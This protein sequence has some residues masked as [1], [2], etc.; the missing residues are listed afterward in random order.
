MKKK[1]FLLMALLCC[2]VLA[3]GIL[4]ACNGDDPDDLGEPGDEDVITYGRYYAVM[5]AASSPVWLQLNPDLTWEMSLG[6]SGTY[7]ITSPYEMIF[8]SGDT[9]TCIARYDA[10]AGAV[11]LEIE[12]NTLTFYM[13]QF[14]G[15]DGEPKFT[16]TFRVDGNI[17]DSQTQLDAGDLVVPPEVEPQSGKYLDGWYT[18]PNFTEKWDFDNNMVASSLDLY[19]RWLTGEIEAV[20]SPGWMRESAELDVEKLTLQL[21]VEFDHPDLPSVID[22]GS[23]CQIEEG[24]EM[25]LFKDAACSEEISLELPLS[26]AA[27]ADGD[28]L[29]YLQTY[30]PDGTAARV[31]TVNLFKQYPVIVYAHD[32][33]G[34]VF[35]SIQ[36]DAPY[37]GPLYSDGQKLETIEQWAEFYRQQGYAHGAFDGYTLTGWYVDDEEY[38]STGMV[39]QDAHV[40]PICTPNEYTVT[41]DAEE[42]SVSTNTVAVTYD[43]DFTF[44]VA[45]R[46]YY[47]FDG[48]FLADGTRIT[49]AN[50]QSTSGW[51]LL[52]DT[53]VYAKYTIDRYNVLLTADTEGAKVIGTGEYDVLSEVTVQAVSPLG[54]DFVG[55][56]EGDTLC[57]TDLEYTFT[58]PVDGVELTAKWTVKD[59]MAGYIFTATDSVCHITGVTDT[60]V[61]EL[62]IP[63]YVTDIADTAFSDCEMLERITVSEDNPGYYSQSGV[64][65]SNNQIEY[66]PL[67]VSGHVVIPEGV[68]RI[69]TYEFE[70]RSELAAITIPNDVTFIGWY[71][72]NG[73]SGLTS[74][75]IPDSVTIIEEYV[76]KDCIGLSSVTIGNGVTI[77]ARGAFSGCTGM[78]SVT[79]PDSVTSIGQYAFQ[80]CSSLESITLPFV[81]L[82]K[83]GTSYT[84]FGYIFGASSSSYNDDYVPDSLKEVTI[85]GGTIGD[86]AFRDCSG[87]TSV[88]IGDGVTNIESDAFS[89]CTG[90]TSIKVD[91][92]N[93]AYASVDGVLYNKAKTELIFI[94]AAVAGDITI[95]HGVT[96]IGYSAFDGRSALTSISIPDSVTDIEDYAFRDC[97]GLTSITIP[98]SVTRIRSSAFEGCINITSATMPTIA[99]DAIPQDSLQTVVLTS[100]E[101]IGNRAFY[102]CSSLTSVT[103]P[104][105]VT[106][107]GDVAFCNCS[108]LTS[109]TIPDSVTNIGSSA[110]SGCSSLTSITIPDGVTNIGGSAFYGCSGLTSITIPDSVTS[111]GQYAVQ[112]CSSL[113]SITLPF[114]GATND[115]T[116]DT[117]FGHIFGASS[118]SS[119][120]DYVPA[121]LKEVVITGGASIDDY[122]FSGCSSLTSVTIPDSVTSIGGNAFSECSS[123]TAVY[124][125]DIA[126]WCGIGFGGSASNPL[127][128]AHNLYLNGELVTDL[129]IPNGV[130]SIGGYAFSGCSSLTSVTIPDGV[131]SIGDRAFWYCSSLTFVNIGDGV[132]SIGYSAFDGCDDLASVTIPNSVTSID[133][134]AFSDCSGLTAVYITD[135]AAWCGIEFADSSSNP[136]YYAHNLYLNGELVTDLVIPDSVTSI[137]RYAFSGCSG[138]TSA[139]IPDSVTSIGFGA[140]ENCSSLESITLPFVGLTKDGTSYTHFGYIFGVSRYND[141]LNAIPVSLQEVVITGGTSIDDHAFYY[142]DSLTSV[143]IPDSV[144]II[145]DWAFYGCS[146]LTS[147]TIGEGVTSI[148]I[149][150]F[151]G[152]INITSAT[153]PTIAIDYI[154][155]ESLQTVVLT[156][157]ESIGNRAFYGC[158][159]LTSV[160]IG[161][162]VTIIG[163]SAFYGC[164]GLTSV[165]IGNGV[166]SI[167]YSA[168]SGCSSLIFVTIPDSVTSIGNYAFDGCSSLASVTIPDSVTSIGSYAFLDCGGLTAV[169]ITNIATWCG[170]DFGDS[171]S[172]PLYHAHDLYLNGKLVTDLV[173]PDSVTSIGEYAFY[174]CSGLTSVTIGNG[175]T[176]M[177]NYAFDGCINITSATMPTIA[178]DAVPQ[179]SLQTVVLTSGESIGNR[180]FYGCSS[181]TSISIPDSVTDIEDYA[182]RDCIGLTSIT[183]PNGVA[184]IGIGA[185]SGCSGLTSVTIGNGVTSI[186][187]STFS[188]CSSLISVTIPDSVTSIGSSAFSGCSSLISVTIPDSVT[189][190]GYS[191][192]SGC[193]S[194]TSVIIP[195][196]VTSIGNYAFDGCSSLASVT[197]P[198]SVTSI[199]YGAFRS[200]S[201]LTSIT[202]PD[203]V[204]SIGQGAFEGCSNITSATMPTLAIDYIPQDSLQTAVLTSGESIGNRAF[205]GC[206]S[207]TSVTIPDSVTSIGDY[208]FWNCRSLTSVTIGD[209]VTSIGDFAFN[210]CSSLTSVAIPDSVTSIGQVAF[211]GCSSLTSVTIPDSVTSI[212]AEAFYGCS[213][214]ISVTVPDGVTSIGDRAFINCSSL[215]SVTIGDGVTSIGNR[216]FDGCSSLT[217]ITIPDCVTSIGGQ[218][219]S[220][221]SSLTSVTIGEGVTS[222]GQEAFSGCSKLIEVYNKSGLDIVAGS[223]GHGEVG[224]YAKNVYTEDG[225]SWFTDTS[226]G[227]R[228]FYDGEQG[229]LMGYYGSA[230]EL[231][232]P[233]SFTAYNGTFVENY[234]IYEYAFAYCNDLI[235]ITIPQ[236]VTNIGDEAFYNC[237]GLSALVVKEGN[238]IYHSAG[239]CIIETDSKTLVVGCKVSMIPNDGSVTRIGTY[240]FSGCT[241]LT[242]ITIPDSVTSIG[243]EAFLG[244]SGLTSITIPDSVTR[245]GG[246]AF[247][248][249]SGLT[250]VTIPDSMTSIGDYAFYNCSGLTS[251]T[252]PDSVTRIGWCAFSG[253]RSLTSVIIP[254][255]VTSIGRS[256]FSGCSGLTSV[257]IPGSV[258]SIGDSAFQNCSGLTS[259]T[260]PDSVTSIG[261]SAFQNCSGLTTVTIPDSVTSIGEEAFSGCSN[262]TA[263]HITDIAAWCR[264]EFAS[265]SSNPLYYAHDLYLNGELV[266]DLVIPNGVTSIGDYAFYNCSGLT[267]VT[268]PDSVTSIGYQAFYG[269]GGLTS[270][271]FEETAGWYYAS[272]STATSGTEISS[273]DLADPAKAAEWLT[274]TYQNYYWKRNV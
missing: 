163:D 233:A 78:T 86:Y 16:V 44:P 221:C 206:R 210:G 274:S 48:W 80:N 129:V 258:T 131:T 246:F 222:I 33:Y 119:N 241:G 211:A 179:D 83:D 160:T 64:L 174:G 250:S 190:I 77:I 65:Y 269:C 137:G 261:D 57:T 196:N 239:N 128:Y 61:T 23:I 117:H 218:A 199:E 110:F 169:Y 187:G 154:P 265:T 146:S 24:V 116:E 180:A 184:S 35:F 19:A 182:F 101:S 138:L 90:L 98:D 74:I 267:S 25:R 18:D 71:A 170:I 188:G 5:P 257:T 34:D 94:P 8:Y 142:C 11:T 97:I 10:G 178:I 236:C 9:Q 30:F 157:G 203:S 31:Y 20:Y 228:F 107:I 165:I 264:I 70:G 121:S 114:V 42:G 259:V 156:S 231:E 147:V 235:S 69:G 2:F 123:L 186:E 105:S 247:S 103:I 215:T 95:P 118:S 89:G 15:E 27:F 244:C 230:T 220:F 195:D 46:E 255:S 41:L 155:Q 13:D 232:L 152:C 201:G 192:F 175:V 115:G 112:N 140:F 248:G 91:A 273:S 43:A 36:F 256:A 132:T 219:F 28:N 143:T 260:I 3:V 135:I 150:A 268:I 159:G 109:V 126:A 58:V 254:D 47:Q 102:G 122:A 168:F 38:N 29:F 149:Y 183:I 252:I 161:D 130:T 270:V 226:D 60:T 53:T 7:E 189:S 72:F 162:G 200:C 6:I 167:G 88:N 39:K 125:T 176:S 75:T 205:E 204:T 127:Y 229:Y 106:S 208:A 51:T 227:F 212:G 145:G 133:Y 49:D 191:T 266:T 67:K 21:F 214:L 238:L 81:G 76:F 68:T 171:A 173:I 59:E 223:T 263:V 185:F 50:G 12:G 194:L 242:S 144:T 272:S 54:Y 108:S 40:Y 262:L 17:Y 166:T 249:C 237:S 111:I 32:P 124:I 62:Y 197:I 213:S 172:N 207:L 79:I 56:Y 85:T 100:G 99:I 153:M 26:E 55:W 148:G 22:F 1:L 37:F 158:S 164:S 104:D 96:S 120:A 141:Q 240:A 92:K 52:N 134:Y 73:C 243:E 271:I 87:L 216:A 14:G 253:C 198:D 93:A 251:V 193:S 136:L 224:Y 151:E 209:G 45:V 245:I 234:E 84:H 66:V 202:I 82:T 4:A 225:G 181:L 139:T 113:E 63:E 177:G 217:S